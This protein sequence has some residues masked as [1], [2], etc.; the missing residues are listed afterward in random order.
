MTAP[1]SGGARQRA[2]R[3]I[4]NLVSEL[5][6]ML[7][8]LEISE[9]LILV[10]HSFGSLIARAYCYR[11]PDR[12]VELL[13]LDPIDCEHW[14]TLPPEGKE[15]LKLG[16]ML[17]RRGAWLARVGVVRFSLMLLSAGARNAAEVDR[18][19]DKWQRRERY[20]ASPERSARCQA[21]SCPRYAHTG[22]A[23]KVLRP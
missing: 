14:R 21:N 10:A 3:S 22:P 11:N 20:R 12:V 2:P 5:E 16:T 23:P 7:D 9:P 6:E 13:L 17:S 15:R 1:V 19:Y 8:S 18:T 4:D